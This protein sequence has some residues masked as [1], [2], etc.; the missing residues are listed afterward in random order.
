S[1]IDPG[2]ASQYDVT[3]NILAARTYPAFRQA[4]IVAELLPPSLMGDYHLATGSPAS[5]ARGLGA[6]S[7]PV[8]WGTGTSPFTYTVSAPSSDIDGQPRPTVTGPAN[9][10]VR[11]YDAGS[12]QMTP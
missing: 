5:S 2:F 11:R 3:V 6:A 12:D 8:S 7:V 10:R 9:N 1:G 4:V